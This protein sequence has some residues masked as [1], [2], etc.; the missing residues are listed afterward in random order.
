M[1]RI[2]KSLLILCLSLFLFACS[3]LSQENFDKVQPDMTMEQVVSILGE[4]SSSQ[5][6]NVAGV[7]GTSAVW[8]DKNAE[9]NIQFVNNKVAIKAYNKNNPQDENNNNN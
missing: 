7:S 1:P 5:S 2:C 3:K 9:I 8:R 6:I 4:P